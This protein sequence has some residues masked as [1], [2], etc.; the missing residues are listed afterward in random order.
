MARIPEEEIE[1]LKREISL[2]RL[3]EAKGVKLKKHGPDLIGLCPFHEDHE[4]SLVIS[5]EKNLWHCLGACQTGG[6][7]IDWM[8]KAEGVSCRHAIELL[9]AGHFSLEAFPEKPRGR[10]RERVA[11][12]TTTR[13]LPVVVERSADDEVLLRQVADYYHET[14]K[15]SPEALGYLQ[16]RGLNNSEMIARFRLGF[17]NRTLGYRL[18]QSNRVSGA[19][20][21]GRLQGLGVI[22]GKGH[23]HFNGSLVIPVLDEQGR[24]TEMYG[25]KVNDHLRAGTPKHLYLPGPHRGVWNIEAL[26]ASKELILCESLID[27]LTFWCAGSRNVTCSYGVEG[28]TDDHRAAVGK[29]G[30]ERVYIA[31]D[32]DEAGD[33][34]AE[35]LAAELAARGIE[36]F[37]VLFPKHMDANEYALK[38]QPAA[39]SLGL[40]LRQAPWMAGKRTGSMSPRHESG[41]A[42]KEAAKKEKVRESGGSRAST[43]EVV[44]TGTA[45]GMDDGH[46]ALDAVAMAAVTP[47]QAELTA[48]ERTSTLEEPA[49]TLAQESTLPEPNTAATATADES[50]KE[51]GSGLCETVGDAGQVASGEATIGKPQLVQS[52]EV[53]EA[54][55][56]TPSTILSLAAEEDTQPAPALSVPMARPASPEPPSARVAS[57]VIPS[58]NLV[59]EPRGSSEATTATADEVVLRFGDRRWRIRGLPPKPMPGT[60][61]VNVL[62]NREKGGFHVDT[63]EL[64]SARQRAAFVKQASEELGVEER[65]V[66]KDLGEVLLRLEELLEKRERQAQEDK[67]REQKLS[68]AETAAALEL[69]RDPR[70]LDRILDDFERCGIVGER[71]NKLMGYLAATSRKLE[72]PLAV[73]IQSSSAAGKSSLMEAIL[74]F[75]PAEQRVEYS[76]MTGQSLFYM[77]E[78]NL[79]H[80][81]LAIVE[82]E[83]AERASYAL[84]L[85]QSEGVLTIASTGK[86]SAT[87]RLITQEYRVEGPVM[88]FLTTTAVD[89]D[90]ELLNRC[91]VLTVDEGRE[92]TRAIHDRQ[93]YLQTLEG[94]LARQDRQQILKL[95][96]DAQR[97]LRPLLVVNPYA[98]ELS[99]L[100]HQTRTRRDHMK[101]L[102]LIR[103][104]ALL[105]QYQRPVKTVEHQGRV[106]RYIEVTKEDI[107]LA[108][109]L[110]HEVLGRSLDELPPQTRKLLGLLGQ[111]VTGE[112]QRLGLDR[113]DY[114]FSRRLVREYT[115]WGDTQLK[116]HLGRLVEMEYLVVHRV[117]GHSQ[118]FGY[119]LVHDPGGGGG[120]FLAGLFNP[121]QSGSCA[122]DGSR[123]GLEVNRSGQTD[124]RS[125]PGRPLVGPRSG[126]GRG[127]ES[128]TNQHQN[129]SR[130]NRELSA[131]ENAHTGKAPT[132]SVV[133]MRN[134]AR[135]TNGRG[136][137][138]GVAASIATVTTTPPASTTRAAAATGS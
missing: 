102:N 72:E 90:E 105:H 71:T 75:M 92:Q 53:T 23:E 127:T 59:E 19:E 136:R 30:I 56:S 58:A 132:S 121:E 52:A 74:S 43:V 138:S 38:V 14:L 67:S 100:H 115:Q 94:L 84:K 27:A 16:K 24:V 65:A 44:V 37:R 134:S 28:F 130:G 95:H 11:K 103:S 6:T 10:Q 111:M 112:C 51:V 26:A 64:Y 122:Y 131:A 85:L 106:V 91:L 62:A 97:L 35:K 46:R 73:V 54:N 25:R 48:T 83:G 129:G 99:F 117:A 86:D 87:G 101:Y 96:Q 120:S 42:E 104:I 81:I 128:N 41:G 119:E 137:G 36:C 2:E 61:R 4:P 78:T 123:P 31:Y 22:N 60:L 114:R 63:L 12:Q 40:A 50:A 76:A 29:H 57:E 98:R 109:R 79:Q 82:E 17:A 77:G 66:K 89:V 15:A 47:T 80:K 9:R 69:L 126:G 107:T 34:A 33:R 3:A 124:D 13:K 70:L 68:A 113:T 39:Q 32:R 133:V 21:R 8:M 5:P 135:H 88:I 45:M 118:R 110:A 7:V 108:N 125:G 49:P 93:R 1:R 55:A 20:L 116:V 18:P